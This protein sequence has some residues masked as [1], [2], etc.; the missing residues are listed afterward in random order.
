ME[1]QPGNPGRL[2]DMTQDGRGALAHAVVAG[3]MKAVKHGFD[4][5][6]KDDK[7]EHMA[8]S[9]FVLCTYNFIILFTYRVFQ[10]P[11]CCINIHQFYT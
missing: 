4:N 2:G 3:N 11:T 8:F 6:D 1:V 7:I 10:K 5:D 9:S